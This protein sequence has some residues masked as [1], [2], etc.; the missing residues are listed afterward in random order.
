MGKN[1]IFDRIMHIPILKT[2]EPFYKR[3]KEVLL[4]LFFGVLSFLISIGTYALFTE[5]LHINVLIANIFAWI[6]SVSFAYITNR[7]WVFNEN[8]TGV[9]SILIEIVKFVSARLASLAVEE[10]IL[11]IFITRM[12]LN[13]M[14]VKIAATSIVII[15]NY[16]SSKLWVFRSERKPDGK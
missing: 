16:A 15:L 8:A 6:F 2:F 10:L 1:D 3:H 5:V 13:S 4:Y 11:Y 9:K 7:I 14:I 12:R